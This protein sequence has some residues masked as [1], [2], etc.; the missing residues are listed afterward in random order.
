MFDQNKCRSK[1]SDTYE[2]TVE[3][4]EVDICVK[5]TPYHIPKHSKYLLIS[6]YLI[7]IQMIPTFQSQPQFHKHH[8]TSARFELMSVLMYTKA[9]FYCLN[10]CSLGST[11]Q[12]D[13]GHGMA[14]ERQRN[15]SIFPINVKVLVHDF[16]RCG[17]YFGP[18]SET[19]HPWIGVFGTSLMRWHRLTFLEVL[20]VLYGE[21]VIWLLGFGQWLP[22][23]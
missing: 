1:V 10:Y 18:M 16:L 6:S 3:L 7:T 22:G 17:W 4:W 5:W 12:P 19:F 20:D 11:P 14:I 9:G 23:L 13:L 21:W 8:T 15:H 2:Y